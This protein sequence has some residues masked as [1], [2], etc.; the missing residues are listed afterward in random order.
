MQHKYAYIIIIRINYHKRITKAGCPAALIRSLEISNF[1]SYDLSERRG[2]A[3][4]KKP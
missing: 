4:E 3:F 2:Y 1:V